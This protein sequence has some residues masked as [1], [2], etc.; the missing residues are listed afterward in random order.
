MDSTRRGAVSVGVSWLVTVGVGVSGHDAV[1]V[2]VV[3]IGSVELDRS[4]QPHTTK[5]KAR[6]PAIRTIP[7]PLLPFC[8][9]FMQS[10]PYDFVTLYLVV[11]LD[12]GYTLAYV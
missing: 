1:R 4:E 10:L 2:G 8:R 6:I 9:T 11:T 12:F 3:G 5:S 7:S